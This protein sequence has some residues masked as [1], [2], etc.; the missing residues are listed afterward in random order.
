WTGYS[1]RALVAPMTWPIFMP[2]PETIIDI[3]CGQ[4]SRLGCATPVW[5]PVEYVIRGVRPNSPVTIKRT[6]LSSPRSYRSSIK[7]VTARSYIG[8]RNLLSLKIWQLTAWE[9]QLYVAS[10]GN[11]W[12]GNDGFSIT[13]VTK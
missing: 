7:A 4:W 8:K 6:R 11:D 5:V 12:P 3:A 10:D 2:P 9:S 13:I 1:P